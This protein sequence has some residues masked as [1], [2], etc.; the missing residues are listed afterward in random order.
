MRPET[1]NKLKGTLV[2]QL[3]ERGWLEIRRIDLPASFGLSNSES[4]GSISTLV[5]A[6]ATHRG[7][8][9]SKVV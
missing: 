2:I 8:F 3:S 1:K 7:A 9:P 6:K 5:Q 4:N